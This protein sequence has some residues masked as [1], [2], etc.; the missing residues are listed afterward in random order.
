MV[1]PLKLAICTTDCISAGLRIGDLTGS[2][3][4]VF[5]GAFNDDYAKL[6]YRD[7]N[8]GPPYKATGLGISMLSNRISHWFD[9]KGP[10]LTVDTACSASTSA[11]HMACESLRTGTSSVSIVAG[12]NVMLEPDVMSGLST[13]KYPK[14]PQVVWYVD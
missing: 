10:S 11:L 1:C 9:L 8:V 5:V 6:L 14:G 4:S 2:N 7:Q 12:A 3:T 13:L